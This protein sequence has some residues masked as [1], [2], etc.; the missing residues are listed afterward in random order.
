MNQFQAGKFKLKCVVMLGDFFLQTNE[1]SLERVGGQRTA[2]DEPADD[3]LT[4][5]SDFLNN[6]DEREMEEARVQVESF[7]NK[8]KR[9]IPIGF[10]KSESVKITFKFLTFVASYLI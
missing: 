2:W 8:K 1:V 10:V 5:R 7:I 9:L 4:V 3:D 6:S